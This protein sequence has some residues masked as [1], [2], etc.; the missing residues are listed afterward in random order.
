MQLNPPRA[1]AADAFAL[2]K[3]PPRAAKEATGPGVMAMVAPLAFPI[4][5]SLLS[6]VLGGKAP[7]DGRGDLGAF[8]VVKAAR[9]RRSGWLILASGGV[10]LAAGR[11]VGAAQAASR[12]LQRPRQG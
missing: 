7:V 1:A 9:P 4:G 10:A 6:P 8:L 3:L 5:L 11:A 12:A 2:P